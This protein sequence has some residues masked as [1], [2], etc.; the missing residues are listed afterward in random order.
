M[1]RVL[2]TGASRGIGRAIAEA[3]L[4]DGYEVTGTS[5]HPEAIPPA[6]RVSGVRYVPLYLN[7]E[8]SIANLA[9]AA[10]EVDVL[11]NNAG[12][13]Q[14][15]AIEEVPMEKARA[16]FQ[17]NFFGAVS[18]IQKVL[19]GM[20]ARRQGTILSVASFAA[21]TPVPFLSFYGASKA[22]LLALHKSLR[23][24][25]RPWGIRVAVVA[26]LD[27]HTSI[28]LDICYSEGS[29]YMPAIATVRTIRD[30]GLAG[31]PGPEVVARLVVKVLH[32]RRPR[33]FTVAGR[34]AWSTGFLVKHLPAGVVERIIRRRY[35]LT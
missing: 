24:E 12:Q 29:S 15:G 35:G 18:L 19:P 6:E 17:S 8:E 27:V 23:Q 13:S 25:L 34:G 5:R 1:K 4:R 22:A 26:P 21:V 16:L 33:L 31:A 28:P 10:G 2:V 7:D 11:I 9:R 20:R 3:L 32:A 30:R 14:I